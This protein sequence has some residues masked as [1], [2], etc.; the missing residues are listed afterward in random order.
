MA[1]DKVLLLALPP[2]RNKIA[3]ATQLNSPFTCREL[4]QS[5]LCQKHSSKWNN[6]F[7]YLQFGWDQSCNT[8]SHTENAYTAESVAC[9]DGRVYNRDVLAKEKKK[10]E[11]NIRGY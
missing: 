9:T 4:I 11:V 6:W 8:H 2:L 5:F 7:Q 1:G 3:M 10:C